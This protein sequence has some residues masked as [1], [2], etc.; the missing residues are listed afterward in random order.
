MPTSTPF[1]TAIHLGGTR[2]ASRSPHN[3]TPATVARPLRGCHSGQALREGGGRHLVGGGAG[4]GPPR[5]LPGG[6]APAPA[7][8]Y[9]PLP[10][11]GCGVWRVLRRY[12]SFHRPCRPL[13]QVSPSSSSCRAEAAARR[14]P[15]PWRHPTAAHCHLCALPS[16]SSPPHPL[17]LPPIG[18]PPP[19]CGAA[20]H[21]GLAAAVPSESPFSLSFL[22][23]STFSPLRA[24]AALRRGCVR[25]R[26]WPQPPAGRGDGRRCGCYFTEIVVSRVFFFYY[27]YF[28]TGIKMGGRAVSSKMG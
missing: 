21:L 13:W 14:A 18:E 27:Y 17:L 26:L 16:V 10:T 25:W 7:P 12:R 9:S 3:A 20:P 2:L 4:L 15:P 5:A 28:I 24:G 8:L 19:C 6:A 1:S 11:E 23:L 22:S